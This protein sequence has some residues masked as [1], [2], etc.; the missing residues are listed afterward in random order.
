MQEY[1]SLIDNF[2]QLR[3]TEK[4]SEIRDELQELLMIFHRLC[5]EKQIDNKILT[6]D[7]MK[8]ID[9]G[10]VSDDEFLN[11]IYAYIISIK[12]TIGKYLN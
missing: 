2:C 11:A 8:K 6:H 3:K 12:E 10:N 9:D 5:M 1:Q 4:K 7:E